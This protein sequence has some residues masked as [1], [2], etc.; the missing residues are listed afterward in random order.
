MLNGIVLSMFVS[1]SKYKSQFNNKPMLKFKI[2]LITTTVINW[3]KFQKQL[4]W[5]ILL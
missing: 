1:K 3:C 2:L 5:N 4:L